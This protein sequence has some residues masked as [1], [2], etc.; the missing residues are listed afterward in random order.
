MKLESIDLFTKIDLKK[1]I[2]SGTWKFA[3]GALAGTG[4][5]NNYARLN[6]TYSP[7]EEY[8]ISVIVERREAGGEQPGMHVIFVGGGKQVDFAIETAGAVSGVSGLDGKPVWDTPLGLPGANFLP[9]GEKKN[10]LFMV[11]KEGIVVQ[12]EGKDW[13]TWKAEWN[14]IPSGGNAVAGA[15]KAVIGFGFD[16][17]TGAIHKA[18][19]MAPKEKQ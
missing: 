14:R 16:M 6:T 17:T 18:V 15:A 19:I 3:G 4:V 5:R 7:P 10:L 13:Y 1:D 9:K 8:D 11:R 2:L 12:L